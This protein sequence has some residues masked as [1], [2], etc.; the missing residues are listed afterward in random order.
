MKK[1]LSIFVV[2]LSLILSGAS[3]YAYF[4]YIPE[5]IEQKIIDSFNTFG[6]EHLK[7]GKI[8]RKHGQIIFSDISLDK[9]EFSTIKEITVHFSLLK[10]LLNPNHA[11]KI[12]IHQLQLTGELSTDHT[13]SISGWI[14]NEKTLDKLRNIPATMISINSSSI[15]IISDQ[16]GG[17][18]VNY[19][20]QIQR[21]DTNNIVI[22]GHADS[23]QKNL[24]FHA[25]IDGKLSKT[26]QLSLTTEAEQISITHKGMSIRRGAAILKFTHNAHENTSNT[27]V[28][29][30]IASVNW[31][32]LPLRDVHAILEKNSTNYSL[33][34][35]GK[36]FGSENIEWETHIS[37]VNGIT[38]TKSTITPTNITGLLSFLHRNQRLKEQGNIPAFILN[39]QEPTLLINT[40]TDHDVTDGDFKILINAPDFEVGGNFSSKN[41]SKNVLG[42]FSVNKTYLSSDNDDI[43]SM[44][45]ARFQVESL[46]EFSISNLSKTAILDW[47][48]KTRINDGRLRYSALT[49]PNI[50]AEFS[51]KSQI[52]KKT[53]KYLNFKLPLKNHIPQNGRINLNLFNKS[54]PLIKSIELGIYSGHIKTRLPILKNGALTQNNKLIVSDINLTQLFYDSGFKNIIITGQLGGVIPLKINKGKMSVSGGIL[55]SQSGGII[56][57]PPHIITGLF[58]GKSRKMFRI[59]N[60]LENYYY[61]YFEI[62]L[63]GNLNGRIMMTL[64]ARG[65]NPMS[66]DK[67]PV[68]LSLQIETQISLLFKNL[69]K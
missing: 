3:S 12:S 25:K 44:A 11:Q 8:T 66:Q 58:P 2:I 18:R 40:T 32:N 53:K 24:K 26:G 46:G 50:N 5:K 13:L 16:L 1:I 68:D 4:I 67:E 59:R 47:S 49:I 36:T 45:P 35:D 48:M 51:Y 14:N 37:Q 9:Q 31:Q 38:E 29:A 30:D 23:K 62:R 20:A 22:K 28:K 64:N 54:S 19:N 33:L 52:P 56:K 60:A 21:I 61:E 55:Q 27:S 6:F 34:A 15:D 10:F 57:L 63:D 69:L 39:F 42:F 17:I 43:E 65:Y 41:G 7:F